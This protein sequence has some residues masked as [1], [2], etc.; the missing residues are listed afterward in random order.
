[1][2]RALPFTMKMLFTIKTLYYQCSFGTKKK[3]AKDLASEVTIRY[4][5]FSAFFHLIITLKKK[6]F[7]FIS[8][9]FSIL[10]IFEICLY[11]YERERWLRLR[12]EIYSS[13]KPIRPSLGMARNDNSIMRIVSPMRPTRILVRLAVRRARASATE[14]LRVRTFRRTRAD[15]LPIGH[16]HRYTVTPR[17]FSRRSLRRARADRRDRSRRRGR[18]RRAEYI[19]ISAKHT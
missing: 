9:L 1:M 19:Y 12:Y 18:G 13:W 4:F 5:L 6:I 10:T 15:R 17:L 7:F 11:E 16:A 14:L 3:S 8:S 2:F